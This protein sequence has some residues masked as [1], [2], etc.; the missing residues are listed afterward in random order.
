V[1]KYFDV[2]G[3]RIIRPNSPSNVTGVRNRLAHLAVLLPNRVR[4]RPV[5]ASRDRPRLSHR[6]GVIAP[7]SG[8]AISTGDFYVEI[9]TG[10]EVA[11]READFNCNR[12]ARG[13]PPRSAG[14]GSSAVLYIG[15][16]ARTALIP[17]SV[18]VAILSIDCAFLALIGDIVAVVLNPGE[19]EFH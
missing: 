7:K 1:N 14:V 6:G 9:D 3:R 5:L 17:W 13:H 11:R 2:R 4:Q 15:C 19:G 8:H 18:G 12:M 10:R 16:T